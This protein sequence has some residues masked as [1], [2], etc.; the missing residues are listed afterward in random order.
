MPDGTIQKKSIGWCM[1][2]LKIVCISD[3]HDIYYPQI[4][5]GVDAVIHAGDITLSGSPD[6]TMRFLRWFEGLKIKHK[7]FIGGNHDRFLEQYGGAFMGDFKSVTYLLDSSYDLEGYKV[8]G[9][10]YSTTFM[11]WFFMKDPEEMEEQWAK[12]PNDADIVVTHGPARGVLDRVAPL[13]G[14]D[15][16]GDVALYKTLSQKAPQYHIC[17]HIHGSRGMT[18]IEGTT[19]INA[20]V[21]DEA[22]RPWHLDPIVIELPNKAAGETDA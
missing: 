14:H 15:H 17:G 12:I 20:A 19:F 13:R 9:S 16:L 5:S 1:S 6:E 10:P 21:L 22:Y 18:S 11:N 2:N 3:T 4:P 7:I 8:W